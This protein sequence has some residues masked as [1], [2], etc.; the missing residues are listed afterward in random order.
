VSG[1]G[2]PGVAWEM[3]L[4]SFDGV[5]AW[6][7]HWMARIAGRVE[8]I[9]VQ[10]EPDA[11]DAKSLSAADFTHATG[12]PTGRF[13]DQAAARAAALVVFQHVAGSRDILVTRY[14]DPGVVLAGPDDLVAAG[15][16]LAGDDWYRWL[17]G[18]TQHEHDTQMGYNAPPSVRRPGEAI[19]R[20]DG[21]GW[22]VARV[23][24]ADDPALANGP[25]AGTGY[26]EE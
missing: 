9:D 23:R 2:T 24:F 14:G 19:V 11:A 21:D 6:A 13:R 4:S 8:D 25:Q 10:Y 15:A 18:F 1:D 26:H 16:A 7:S 12:L 22:A 3:T 20:H 17:A 5:V